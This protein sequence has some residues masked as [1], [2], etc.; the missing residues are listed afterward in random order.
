MFYITGHYFQRYIPPNRLSGQLTW[1]IDASRRKKIPL[2]VHPFLLFPVKSFSFQ[3]MYSAS[4]PLD[5]IIY[6][7]VLLKCSLD[8]FKRISRE[9]FT[10][11]YTYKKK[12]LDSCKFSTASFRWIYVFWDVLNMIWPFL[13]NVCLLICTILWTLYLKK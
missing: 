8:I 12:V 5:P 10:F 2:S 7:I 1:P 11:F 4:F 13:E 6:E 9:F 3:I